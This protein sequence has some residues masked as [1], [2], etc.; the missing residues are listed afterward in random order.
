MERAFLMIHVFLK[1]KK[2]VSLNRIKQSSKLAIIF[3]HLSILLV[4]TEACS[5][6]PLVS[7]TEVARKFVIS[8]NHK[9]MESLVGL[10]ATPL[11]IRR[12]DWESAKDGGGFVLGKVN[13]ILL[14]DQTQIKKYFSDPINKIR[15][16]RDVP[17]DASLKLLQD[18][19]RGA[20][21]VWRGLS[22]HLFLRGMGDVEHIF[23]VGVDSKGK[24]AAVYLN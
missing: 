12:Q 20:E 4:S 13:D 6:T 2:I 22:I 21:K 18:Q 7:P 19:L 10:S 5:K 23:V 15:V 14:T 11:W 3:V 8:L 9:D 17:N 16:E 1:G 24:I